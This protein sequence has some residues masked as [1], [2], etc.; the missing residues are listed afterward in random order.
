M[1]Q[2]VS[3][4]RKRLLQLSEQMAALQQVFLERGP[5]LPGKVYVLRRRCGKPTCRCQRGQLHETEVLGYRGGEHAQTITPA[6][7]ERE[8][9]RLWTESYRRFRQARAEL[10]KLQAEMLEAI[11]AIGAMRVEQGKRRFERMRS[12]RHAGRRA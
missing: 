5:L 8:R 7:E 2:S 9:L 10:V 6:P 3:A 12:G 1:P 4:L 11:D